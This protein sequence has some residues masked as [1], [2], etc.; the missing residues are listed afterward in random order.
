ERLAIDVRLRPV[1]RVLDPLPREAR[2]L[3]RK[4]GKKVRL[5]ISGAETELDRAILDGVKDPLLHLLR[6][7]LDHGIEP[8]QDRLGL[9]KAEE[10]LGEIEASQDGG[11]VVIRM[12]DDGRGMDPAVLRASAVRKGLLDRERALRL[13]DE[14]SFQLVFVAGFSTKE[15]TSEIS[16]RG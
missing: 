12:R 15:V 11:S 13:T 16:G 4:L 7:A 10:G 1:A 9:G 3:A 2:E 14:E 5:K 8:P 6:N